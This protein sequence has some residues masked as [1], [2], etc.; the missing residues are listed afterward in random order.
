[1]GCSASLPSDT[2]PYDETGRTIGRRAGSSASS[3]HGHDRRALEES[4]GGSFIYRTGALEKNDWVVGE[5]I[6][7]PDFLDKP[8]AVTLGGELRVAAGVRS[9]QGMNAAPPHKPNQDS[10]VLQ[11]GVGLLDDSLLFGVFDGHGPFGDH[12]SHFCRMELPGILE[13]QL[14]CE[15]GAIEPA[16]ALERCFP[17]LQEKL[18]VAVASSHV[19][20]LVSGTTA[21]VGL[22]H[23]G[24][25]HV[26]NVGDSRAIL[27]R[28]EGGRLHAR[29]LSDDHKP[30]RADE[31]KRI[32]AS[33]AVI[34]SEADLR[35]G[36]GDPS[37]QFVCRWRDG[38]IWYG[39][40]FSRS[41]GDVDS[42][43]HLGI[44]HE[45][46]MS[47]HEIDAHDMYVI[48]ASDGVWDYMTNEEVARVIEGHGDPQKA[49]KAL[50][51]EARDRWT[52][53]S[54]R[55]DDITAVCVRLHG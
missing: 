30:N 28:R 24:V 2:L 29:A 18:L 4:K 11:H 5:S 27:V 36:I 6:V 46:E 7:R 42:H 17:A 10:W 39:I 44:S 19:D 33:S 21:I 41:I 25:L 15:E 22:L 43:T 20:P 32:S 54:V 13:E 53:H 31:R 14:G 34:M 55:R 45:A 8:L 48:V 47:V 16:A 12:L 50:V 3:S 49:A 51:M 26:A 9:L 37:K 35:P 52:T 40:M 1:M 38:E 23:D